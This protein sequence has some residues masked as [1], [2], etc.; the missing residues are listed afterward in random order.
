MYIVRYM[1][2]KLNSYLLCRPKN[3][4][5]S[6]SIDLRLVHPI[7][8]LILFSAAGLRSGSQTWFAGKSM[9]VAHFRSMMFL[10]YK[11]PCSSGI[12]QQQ[13]RLHPGRQT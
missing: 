11:P 1:Y 6:I 2:V 5:I 9:K 4:T 7:Y 13:P 8:D 3:Q 10:A 12:S